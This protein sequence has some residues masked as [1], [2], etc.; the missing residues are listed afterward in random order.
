MDNFFAQNWNFSKCFGTKLYLNK[1]SQE[2]KNFP[3]N[4]MTSLI[5]WIIN[6]KKLKKAGSLLTKI[7]PHRII[8]TFSNFADM[9]FGTRSMF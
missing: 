5:M 9:F 2:K 8:V 1:R 7:S 4:L 6:E 3:K